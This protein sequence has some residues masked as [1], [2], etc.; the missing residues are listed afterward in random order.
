MLR[1]QCYDGASNMS[2]SVQGVHT[3]IQLIQP[4]ALYLHCF[5]HSLNLSVQ[6]AVRSIPLVRDVMQCLRDL[7]TIVR[8]SAKRFDAFK[9]IASGVEIDN[10]VS[11]RPLCPTR[12]TVRFAATDAA[13]R[14]YAVI[15]PFLSEVSTMATVDDSA[16]KA[17]GLLSQFE[18]GHIYTVGIGRRSSCV[19][20]D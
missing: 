17:R 10:P 3:R 16:S 7:A 11:P 15:L 14:S 4:K 5:A 1:G 6:D 2:G 19:R 13:L 20:R 18:N 12:W 9:T 8:G